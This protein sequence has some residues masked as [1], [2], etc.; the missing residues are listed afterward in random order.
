MFVGQWESPWDVI[1]L[2]YYS[3]T[4]DTREAGSIPALGVATEIRLNT[5]LCWFTDGFYPTASAWCRGV[6]NNISV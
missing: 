2:K 3:P 5:S 6:V 1:K 4:L